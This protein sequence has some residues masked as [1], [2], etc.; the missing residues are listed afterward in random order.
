[1]AG[2]LIYKKVSVIG[3]GAAGLVAARELRREGHEVVVFERGSHLGGLWV[4]SS[5]VESDPLGLDPS[6]KLIHSSLYNSVRVNVARE[7]M[8]FR[9]F[10]FVAT[11]KANRD[12]QRFPCHDEV[13][14]YL[15]DFAHE[16]GIIEL[17]RYQ[18]EVMHVALVSNDKWKVKYKKAG[19]DEGS[20][21][22]WPGR[23]IHSHNYRVPKPYQD[24]VVV[25]I[26]LSMSAVEISVELTRFAKQV[27]LTTRSATLAKFGKHQAYDNLWLHPM[28]EFMKMEEYYFKMGVYKYCFPF[29]HTNG[30]VTVDDNRVGPLYKHVFPPALAPSLSFVGI[31]NA[32]VNFPL[33]EFQSKWIA[34]ALSGR[35]PLPS[36][37]IMMEDT[38]AFYL[39][40]EVKG[41]KKCNTHK[42]HDFMR[43]FDPYD[44]EDF[45]AKQSG[46]PLMEEWKKNMFSI[47]LANVPKHTWSYRDEITSED[48]VLIKEA[49]E[50]FKQYLSTEAMAIFTPSML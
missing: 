44:Y 38:E 6:R 47:T 12:S 36:E 24:Q 16:F 31:P 30:V 23:Q 17:I 15:E 14:R 40:L 50:D 8:G 13:L 2:H 5:E 46:C 20:I 41:V 4:Y 37:E 21:D 27:H 43:P 10:P 3:G 39:E 1:M 11:G 29:L 45:I 19:E 49:H 7:A 22:L 35:L 18:T 48:L 26:G 42:I 33:Y 28:K 9:D 32:V 25:L 34:G